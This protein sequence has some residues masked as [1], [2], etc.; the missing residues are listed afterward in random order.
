V[1]P[2]HFEPNHG[3]TDPQVQ[4]VAA[5]T[6][7]TFFLVQNGA[8]L[9]SRGPAPAGTASVDQPAVASRSTVRMQIVGAKSGV[10]GVG[11]HKLPGKANYF[12]GNDPAQWH[13]DIPTYAKVRYA[14][15]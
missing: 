1:L 2:L 12:L 7:F 9:C 4:F 8:V 13:T 6:S 11:E 10:N 5:G 15:V 3:Q 14:N